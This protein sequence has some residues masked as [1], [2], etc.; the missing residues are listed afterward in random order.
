MLAAIIICLLVF[1]LWTI[2]NSMFL[3]SLPKEAKLNAYP[4]ISVLVP[5]RNE[6]RNAQAFIHNIQQLTYP[7][8]EVIVL[9]DQSTD[10]TKSILHKA[11]GLDRRFRM[12]SGKPLPV[13]WVG[14]VHACD[15]LQKLANGDYLLFIDADV[16]L[17]PQTIEKSLMLL[18][19]KRAKLLSGFPSFEVPTLLSKLLVPM[20]HFVVMLHLPI[21]LANWTITPATT[22]V[23]GAFMFFEHA[24]YRKMGTHR[25]VHSSLVEDVHIARKMKEQ[26]YRVL[27][28][29][30][31]KNVSCRMYATNGETWE[32]F[33]KNIFV[34]VGRSIPI[35][36]FL[37]IFYS[38]FY[39]LPMFLLVYGVVTFQ[40]LY[41]LPYVI[42][43]LQKAFVDWK[44]N[45][46][47]YIS[48]L[49]PLSATA[50][51]AVLWGSTWKAW[52][53]QPYNWKGR[54]YL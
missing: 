20:Q 15:Q 48:C 13:G 6:M 22:A 41:V 28:A 30:I 33:L 27:L 14:K 16:R 12:I 29:N 52:R 18:Q 49:M 8:M 1:F 32:G 36:I 2:I 10:L 51:V 7:N 23:N 38:V 43:T 47:L 19:T 39:I 42:L 5:M 31:T 53:K 45:Q 3:P 34:G 46:Q 37:T 25:A 4:L 11:I 54:N 35:V 24:A 50:L 9:D 26:G 44:S 17:Q 40:P 21:A